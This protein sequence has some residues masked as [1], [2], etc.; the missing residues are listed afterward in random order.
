VASRAVRWI[1][2]AA[3][4][5]ALVLPATAAQADPAPAW[6]Q[7]G[8]QAVDGPFL[9]GADA[10]VGHN[11]DG[12][13]EFFTITGN[14]IWHDWQL[15]GGGWSGWSDLGTAGGN[16]ARRIAVTNEADGRLRVYATFTDWTLHTIAQNCA[17]CGWGSWSGALNRSVSTPGGP[18]LAGRD[19]DGRVLVFA[20][21]S[22][23]HS[24]YQLTE[25][26]PNGLLSPPRLAWTLP[27]NVALDDT[28]ATFA[29]N[30]D[31]RPELFLPLADGQ[32][33][34]AW[35]WPS[36]AW[37]SWTP[38]G[39]APGAR[40]RVVNE[41]GGT[42]AA[43]SA[44]TTAWGDS[45]LHR[46]AQGCPNCGWGGWQTVSGPAPVGQGRI[47]DLAVTTLPS[48]RLDVY[49]TADGPGSTDSGH[50][51]PYSLRHLAQNGAGQWGG[52]SDVPA[53][54]GQYV[55]PMNPRTGIDASGH[56]WLFVFGTDE[57][58]VHVY[59]APVT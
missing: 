51:F 30:A 53:P 52:W 4:L 38:L 15:T 58:Q 17:N 55:W 19:A 40:V 9:A 41:P 50:Q 18:L 8:S 35:Q 31:G 2:I 39:G 33:Y 22:D 10:V 1:V 16:A 48:G 25:G 36:G 37:S 28:V 59:S 3:G 43:Y 12:R 14:R 57:A 21:G 56:A 34:H 20:L 24:V 49:A 23:W 27:A 13:L 45:A 26:W 7:I 47:S 11:A 29:N 42:L 32:T 44:G 46:V 6:A 54:P 5:A